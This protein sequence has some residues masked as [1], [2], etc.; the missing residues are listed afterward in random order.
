MRIKFKDNID[1]MGSRKLAFALS[2]IM[3][4]ASII[5]ITLRGLNLG[6]DFTG[7]TVIE[8]GYP[9]PV[10]LEE[11]R[12]SLAKAGHEDA[13]AQYFGT[14]KEVLIRI[15]PKEGKDKAHVSNEIIDLLKAD[16]GGKAEMK[17]VEFV[18]PQIGEELREEGGMAML[19]ALIGILIYVSFRF[20]YRFSFG[21]VIA[22]VHDVIITV[23]FFALTQMEFDLTVLAA[24]LAV[25]GY[26]LN[27]TIVVFDRIRENFK[28]IRKGDSKH[29][30][31]VSINQTVSRTII[32]SLTTLLVLLA[33]F[34][35]GGKIIHSFSVA[36][37][38]GIVVG[39]YSSIYVASNAL[40]TMG[41]SREDLLPP[42]RDSELDKMP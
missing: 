9:E 36:L 28:L 18:G 6:L 32:T 27:D 34:F 25:I 35:F 41:V 17:R 26:S 4:I 38:V 20:E 29:V 15:A 2:G 7:G 21:A 22:L 37:I 13:V 12:G 24:V 30:I 42:A 14:S 11:I 10:N 39:T 40:L 8:I 31:N 16:S 1:F 19:Y 5:F 23:G 33:L 3:I